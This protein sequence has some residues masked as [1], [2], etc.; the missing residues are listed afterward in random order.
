MSSLA[1]SPTV[2]SQRQVRKDLKRRYQKD[3]LWRAIKSDYHYL[4]DEDII[5]QC[6][7]RCRAHCIKILIHIQ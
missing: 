2:D 3:E 6:R 7:V 5:E 1:H 4:M